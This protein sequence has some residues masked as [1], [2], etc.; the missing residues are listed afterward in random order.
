METTERGKFISP[1]P[2]NWDYLLTSQEIS[3]QLMMEHCADDLPLMAN[4]SHILIKHYTLDF[5]VCFETHVI[6]G[7]IVLFLEPVGLR[8]NI[9][10][11][12]RALRPSDT[13]TTGEP[14]LTLSDV[15]SFISCSSNP[16]D[17]N[18][19]INVTGERDTS[20]KYDHYGNRK[21]A[22]G[23]TF[24][25]NRCDTGNHE[26][27][28]FILVLDCCDLSVLKVEE[29][30]VAAVP[31]TEKFMS[32]TMPREASEEQISLLSELMALPASHWKDQLFYYTLCSKAPG[33]GDLTYTLDA[34]S[35]QIKKA[36]VKVAA[37]FP[38]VLRIWYKTMA[39]GRSVKW[40]KDQSGRPCVYTI[41]AAINNRALFPCQE[42]PVAMSTW[43]A[44]VR[45]ASAFV[46]LMSGENTAVPKVCHEGFYQWF[47]YVTMPMPASTFTIAVGC[48]E[49][50]KDFTTTTSKNIHHCSPLNMDYSRTSMEHCKHMDYPCRFRSPQ[51]QTQPWIPHRIFAPLQLLS[52]C[53]EML[54]PLLPLCLEAAYTML[55]THPFS[56]LDILIVP[57]NFSSL[58][59][60]SPHIIYLSQSI[61]S[62]KNNLCMTRV[63]HEIAHAWFGLAIGAR[64]W[65]EEWISEGFATHL[66]DMFLINVKKLSIEEANDLLEL[67]AILRLRRLADEV[68]NSE[69][70]LQILRPHGEQTG[71]VSESGASI[72]R[73][74]LN[75]EKT[76]M[77]VHYLKGYFLLRFIANKIGHNTYISF[78]KNFVNAFHGQLILSKDFCHM[79]T[80]YVP[81]E[82]KQD[83][84][85]E[86]IY[87]VWL[88]SPGIPKPLLEESQAW[89]RNPLVQQ[90]T[91]EVSKWIRLNQQS[92]RGTKRKR[93][94]SE[95][96]D[97]K[98]LPD[99]LV[100][101]LDLLL[102]EKTLCPKTLHHL[103][104]IYGLEDQDAEIRHRWCELAV[105]HRF[106][107]AYKDV[108][109]FLHQDQAMG[110]YLY[111]ELMV[112][113]NTRQQELAHRCFAAVRD[114]MDI[115]LLNGFQTI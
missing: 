33:C 19:A 108:E 17:K 20:A 75:A 64:D 28:D 82:N 95:E 27:G 85:V 1:G 83:L 55:G 87:Q 71:E 88:D 47:Y 106:T 58:G 111:G 7:N 99:Q 45:A 105:K 81:E 104:K 46:V 12:T 8:K 11:D 24:S 62:G 23:I 25:E 70:D 13:C 35:L 30:D 103:K 66:E 77:Q 42:P 22:S 39:E 10:E 18:C 110:V 43:Q 73:H 52:R 67:R 50:V 86:S 100:L 72:V 14:S 59:M 96:F 37:N 40:T 6:T 94:H 51:T 114:D 80:E 48:W 31:C 21:Q 69:E 89:K 32:S 29:L 54:L 84:S 4:T 93:Q 74:G 112:N 53:T 79:M 76:F 15:T 97:E 44:T 61:L 92:K 38:T 91:Q 90:V 60:A 113:E 115:E 78:L 2:Y 57:S 63:C 41:G 3:S 26:S 9:S 65:T 49:E 68:K 36:G 98:I 56:R 16:G 34:W 101:L 107:A 5:D 109:T 102:E